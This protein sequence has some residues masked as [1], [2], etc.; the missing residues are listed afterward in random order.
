M[1]SKPR[2][3]PSLWEGR[4]QR[5]EGDRGASRC[6]TAAIPTPPRSFVATLPEGGWFRLLPLLASVVAGTASADDS[7]DSILNAEWRTAAIKPAEV[8]SDDEF[9]RRISLDLIGRIPTLDELQRF[10]SNADRAA[11]IEE[12]LNSSDF[13]RFWSEVWTAALNGYSNEFQADREV[14]RAWLETSF[15]RNV[16]YDHLAS[17]LIT[18][19]GTSALDG[20]VNFLVRHAE[21]P[22][23]KVCRMFVGVRLDCARCHDHP[24]DRWTEE[25]FRLM[26]RFFE[27]MEREE[28]SEGNIRV[29]NRIEEVEDDERPRFLT[30]ARPRTTQWRDELALF[31]THSKPFARTYANRVWYH[32]LGR[33]IVH[34]ID[35]FNRENPAASRPLL[36]FLAGKAREDKFA[37]WPMI[38]LICNSRAYQL[39]SRSPDHS[40]KAESLFAYRVLK[41]LT[42]EQTFDSAVVALQMEVGSRERREFIE[43]AVGRSLDEDF[44]E[45]WKYRETVQGLMSRLSATLPTPTDSI[46]ELYQR[47]LSRDPTE[48]EREICRGRSIEDVAFALVNSNEF[49]FNH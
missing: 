41:P 18:A 47:V 1:T 10:R 9:L 45:T 2:N 36:E 32:F 29:R 33:G 20:P 26:N 44:S 6:G 15:R 35:D 21:D 19:R 13:P 31:M 40:D 5:G 48:R 17:Q 43:R 7:I 8:C 38:R 3:L 39:S 25:D 4:V 37:I 16:S 23:V 30:G 12:L 24:F 49:Y 42:P 34:P 46:D 28:V 14:L 27:T 22:A 11:K